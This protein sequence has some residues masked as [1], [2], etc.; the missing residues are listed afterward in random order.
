MFAVLFSIIVVSLKGVSL[1]VFFPA[2]ILASMIH[3]T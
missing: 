2:G 1:C 3:Y